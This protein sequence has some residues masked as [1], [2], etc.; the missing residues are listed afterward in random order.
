MRIS[1]AENIL[2][3][4]PRSACQPILAESLWRTLPWTST[5][6]LTAPA[7]SVK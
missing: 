5:A 6:R 2:V 4:S 1:F 7:R 3:C